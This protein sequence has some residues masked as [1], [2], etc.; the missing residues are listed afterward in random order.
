MDTSLD[1]WQEMPA[2]DRYRLG[3]GPEKD[4]VLLVP[5]TAS[6]IAETEA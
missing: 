3:Y 5:M 2:A 4:W 1:W 6:E